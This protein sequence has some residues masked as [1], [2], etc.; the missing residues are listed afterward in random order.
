MVTIRRS[1]AKD[2]TYENWV[3]TLHCGN[4]KSLDVFEEA[5]HPGEHP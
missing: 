2:S 4:Q 5:L 1:D 3:T